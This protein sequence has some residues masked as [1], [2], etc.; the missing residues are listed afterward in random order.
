MFLYRV[1]QSAKLFYQITMAREDKKYDFMAG[2]FLGLIRATL[3]FTT[4]GIAL[5]YRQKVFQNALHL[6]LV[7]ASVTTVYSWLVDL[8]GDWGLLDYRNKQ[9]LRTKLLFSKFKVGYYV[10]ALL[11]LALR[12]AWTLSITPFVVN[13]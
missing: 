4:A 1:I 5:L 9:I 12:A 8:K 6:W 10:I 11:D 13:S 7:F 2:P 3:S